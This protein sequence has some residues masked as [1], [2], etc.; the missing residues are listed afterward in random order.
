MAV[1]ALIG[2][3]LRGKFARRIRPATLRWTIVT[4]GVAVFIVYLMR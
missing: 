4:F 1:G 3:V 2:G